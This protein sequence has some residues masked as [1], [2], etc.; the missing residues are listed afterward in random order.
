MAKSE[1]FFA[2]R[3]QA[4]YM[5]LLECARAQCDLINLLGSEDQYEEPFLQLSG[6]WDQIR[7]EIEELEQK[8]RDQDLSHSDT[9][10]VSIM[11]EIMECMQ[12][13]DKQLQDT[14]NE[15]GNDLRTVKDQRMIVDAYYGLNR[16]GFKSMY[17][18]EKK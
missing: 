16:K 13:M 8:V 5:K 3:R 1:D 4:L 15:A 9:S 11:E 2:N 7:A 14:V 17:F 6:Q 18:D 12:T 10:L